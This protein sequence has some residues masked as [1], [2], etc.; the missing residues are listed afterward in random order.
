MD[1]QNKKTTATQDE[2]ME[3]TPDQMEKVSGGLSG[4]H[5]RYGE[6]DSEDPQDRFDPHTSR[7]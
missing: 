1:N 6:G 7:P 2:T 3:L 5:C 4:P